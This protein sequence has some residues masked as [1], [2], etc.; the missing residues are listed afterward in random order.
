[1]FQL[2][3]KK[4]KKSEAELNAER[5]AKYNNIMN[6]LRVQLLSMEKQKASAATK[7]V[8]A[9]QQGLS[10]QVETGKKM[11]RRCLAI[12]KR[13]NGMIMN[14]E[15]AMQSREIA[16]IS[17]GFLECM[18]EIG[19][20]ISGVVDKTDAKKASKQYEKAMFKLEKQ[21]NDIDTMLEMSDASLEH[22]L[23]GEQYSA[24]YD[25]EIDA[26]IKQAEG[27]EGM[28]SQYNFDTDTL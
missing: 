28:A 17:K 21:T 11:M 19:A 24:A 22:S 16:M 23:A 13:I 4:P 3:K 6:R 18:G 20:D 12:E 26:L 9:Q 27:G 10:A 1:M 2:F 14:L 8:R 15:Y 25:E 5:E 7:V